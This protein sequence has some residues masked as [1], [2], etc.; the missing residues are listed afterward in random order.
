[1]DFLMV[2]VGAD[3]SEVTV[4]DIG[5]VFGDEPPVPSVDELGR[6][7]GTNSYEILSRIGARVERRY[8]GMSGMTG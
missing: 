7:A 6:W 1:M 4:G 5:T 2:D 8:S 3:G